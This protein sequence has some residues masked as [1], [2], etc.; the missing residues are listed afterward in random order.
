MAAEV[1]PLLQE[2]ERLA[3]ARCISARITDLPFEFFRKEPRNA[4]AALRCERA[5]APQQIPFHGNSDV[6]FHV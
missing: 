3:P 2:R 6:L 1:Q 5:R 4:G